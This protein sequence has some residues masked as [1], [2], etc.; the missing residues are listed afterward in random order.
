MYGKYDNVA[1]AQGIKKMIEY[2]LNEGQKVSADLGYI[3]LP[4]NIRQKVA[5]MA[6]KISPNYNIKLQYV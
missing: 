6:D 2:C 3:P 5:E 4:D 1:I